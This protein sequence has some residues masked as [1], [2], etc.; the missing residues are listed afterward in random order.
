MINF[1]MKNGMNPNT[2]TLVGHSFGAQII[3]IAGQNVTTKVNYLV[4]MLI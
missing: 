4:G 1:L 3:G 2:T